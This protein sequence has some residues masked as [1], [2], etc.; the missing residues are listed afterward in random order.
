MF[1][2][3]KKYWWFQLLGWSG[4]FL[5]HLFFAWLYGKLDTPKDQSL[6]FIRSGSFV[7][8]GLVMTHIMRIFIRKLGLLNHKIGIQVLNFILL[9]FITALVCGLLEQQLFSRFF[10]FTPREFEVLKRR[11]VWLM[12]IDGTIS[13]CI[14][15]FLWNAVYIIYH[16][17]RDYQQQQ[18]DTLR[19]K[20]VVRELELKTIKSN[21][22]PHFIFNALN[23]IRALVDEN[24]ERARDAITE[25]SNIL[26]SSITMHKTETVMLRKE[27]GIVEDYLALEQVRFEDRLSVAYHIDEQILDKQIPPMILHTLVENAIKHG[28]GR[29]VKGGAVSIA[30]TLK[31]NFLELCVQNTGKLVYG[32]EDTGFGLSSIRDRLKLLYPGRSGFEIKQLTPETVEAKIELP[33]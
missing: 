16:Y 18:I 23:S 27:L 21:I 30:A 33:V 13:W 20:S 8:I 17:E 9:S 28:I 29:E 24:P 10:L 5:I 1:T 7:L 4:F 26:R 15:I 19:L 2:G 6:F 12:S 14:Y 32:N 25:L 3:K 22:N 31:N 11:G